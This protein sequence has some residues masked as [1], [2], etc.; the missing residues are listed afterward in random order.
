[1]RLFLDASAIVAIIAGE[2]GADVLA[3]RLDHFA[4][5]WT[6]PVARWEAVIALYRS[7]HYDWR[8]AQSSVD[9]FLA[10]QN[11]E[12]VPIGEREGQMAL[13]VFGN[14]GK[15]QHRAGLN[16]GDC[17]AYACAE[18]KNACLLYK[19]NDFEQ[20]ELAWNDAWIDR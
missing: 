6:S 19:G 12:T 11:V 5:R 8:Y 7:H 20:T 15:G 4:E 1:M 16:M 13:S 17:F 2:T 3:G 10:H 9:D 14:F 18:L